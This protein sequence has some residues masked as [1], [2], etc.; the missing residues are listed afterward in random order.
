MK[1]G[2]RATLDSE[3]SPWANNSAVQAKVEGLQ[4]MS[5]NLETYTILNGFGPDEFSIQ[6]ASNGEGYKDAIIANRRAFICNVSMIDEYGD[7]T[8]TVRMRDRIMYSPINKFDTFPRSFFI[9]V[10]LCDRD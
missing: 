9:D 5:E 10:V 7:G 4:L 6:L 8:E 1:D 3:Y 2:A